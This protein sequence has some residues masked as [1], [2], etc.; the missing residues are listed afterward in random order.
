MII[1]QEKQNVAQENYKTFVAL[2]FVYEKL[3]KSLVSKNKQFS[4][5]R[6]SDGPILRYYNTSK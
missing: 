5:V 4:E 3:N 1:A 6:N 2:P